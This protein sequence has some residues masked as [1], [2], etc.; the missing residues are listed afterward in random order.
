MVPSR[1]TL[2]KAWPRRKENPNSEVGVETEICLLYTGE[3]GMAF[4][5]TQRMFGKLIRWF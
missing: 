2:K 4:G 3:K 5:R 1:E